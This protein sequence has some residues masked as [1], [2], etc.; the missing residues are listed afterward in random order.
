[1]P[2]FPSNFKFGFSTV[3]VQHELGTPGSEFESDWILWLRDP[4]NIIAGIVSGDDPFKGPGYWDF[5][6]TDHDLASW[7]GMNAAWITVEWARIFP[8]PTRD[9]KVKAVIEEGKVKSVEVGENAL[10][11]L[12]TLANKSALQ[13]YREIIEDWRSRGGYVILNLFHWSLPT[14]LH[15]PILVR[16]LGPDRAPSGWL[17]EG[18]VVEFAKFVAYVAEKLG[19][20]AD[21]WYTMNEPMVVARSGYLFVNSGFPPGYLSLEAYE[22]VKLRLAEAHARAYEILKQASGKRVGIV[23]SVSPVHVLSGDRDLSEYVLGEQL[24]VVDAVTRGRAGGEAREDLAG[25]CDWIGL[26]YYSRVVVSSDESGGLRFEEGYGYSCT[27]G[28]RSRDGRPCSDVG[29]EVYP[30]GMLEVGLQLWERYNLPIYIT[31]NGVAD[32]EDKLRPSFILKHLHMVAELLRRGVNVGGYFHWNLTDNL[33][34]SKG[35]KPRFGLVEV[36]YASKKRRLRPSALVFREIASSGEL[37][38]AAI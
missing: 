9:V 22:K 25:R 24:S 19:D 32:S 3:G 23:E 2:R 38:D 10:R 21:E 27:P 37:P 6:R 35:F 34:W 33:E 16:R 4:E 5:F 28:G 20:L 18:T 7:L 15:N 14:W 36:D 8:K 31:E 17:D 26:N 1:M 29:W 11:E 30:E 12:D 13:R